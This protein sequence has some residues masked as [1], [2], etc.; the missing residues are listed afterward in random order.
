M[1]LDKIRTATGRLFSWGRLIPKILSID[2]AAEAGSCELTTF[3]EQFFSQAQFGVWRWARVV[4]ERLNSIELIRTEGDAPRITIRR[5]AVD[6]TPLASGDVVGDYTWVTVGG[7]GEN[8]FTNGSCAR[9]RCVTD[10]T[11]ASGSTP[12]RLEWFTTPAGSTTPVLRCTLTSLG[13]LLINNTTGT[14]TLSVD[15]TIGLTNAGGFYQVNN[16]N[17]LGARRTGWSVPTG[18]SNRGTFATYTAPTITNPPTQAEVQG[19]ANNLQ[20]ISRTLKALI[21]DLTA[22]GIIGA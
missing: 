11:P 19:L 5:A 13:R 10:G 3:G 12:T 2:P 18:S 7:V 15:G 4:V 14:N 22:H 8:L 17:V 21:D 9:I 1:A 6:A 20:I 16:V